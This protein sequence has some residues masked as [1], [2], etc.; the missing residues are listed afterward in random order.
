MN[1]ENQL[2][3]TNE[4]VEF[5]NNHLKFKTFKKITNLFRGIQTAYLNE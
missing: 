5:E 2:P 4:T 1:E 3:V